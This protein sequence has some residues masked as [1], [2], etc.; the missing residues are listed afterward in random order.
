L[1]ADS[2]F[3]E[4]DFKH[5][6]GADSMFV[7][8]LPQPA[9]S[10]LEKLGRQKWMRNFYLAGGSGAALHLGHR[11][12]EDLDFFAQRDLSTSKLI[13]RLKRPNKFE[14]QTEAWEIVTGILCDVRV[15]FFTYSYPLVEPPKKLFG[16]NVASLAD[17]GLMKLIAI[18]QRG[19]RRDFVDLFFICQVMPLERLMALLPKKYVGVKY[20]LNHILRS[21]VY[22]ADAETEPMPKMIRSIRWSKVKRFFENE[23]KRIAQANF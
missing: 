4:A 8:A 21:L 1:K 23:V 20:S 6:E 10:L 19:S 9:R 5:P 15:S 14:L 2:K 16:V 11:V 18:S 17:I 7:Q 12:S 22:F 13:Q 3:L